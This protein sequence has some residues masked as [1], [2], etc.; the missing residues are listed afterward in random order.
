MFVK[1]KALPVLLLA[2]MLAVLAGYGFNYPSA[3]WDVMLQRAPLLV[4][5]K[6]IELATA[7][8]GQVAVQPVHIENRGNKP[9]IIDHFRISCLCAGLE[10]ENE[11]VYQRIER[12]KIPPRDVLK[13]VM[14]VRINGL[15]GQPLRYDL[16]FRTNDPRHPEVCLPFAV[17]RVTGAILA[18]P[19][20]VIFSDL[21]PN[22]PAAPI[23]V[24][25]YKEKTSK[26]A[27]KNIL[28]DHPEVF[29]IRSLANA[30]VKAPPLRSALGERTSLFAVHLKPSGQ[31]GSM[32]SQIQVQYE[33][34]N[35]PPL[36]IPIIAEVRPWLQCVPDKVHLPRKVNGA[37]V[38]QARFTIK[39]PQP[40]TLLLDQNRLPDGLTI[41]WET[42]AAPSVVHRGVV[43]WQ[44]SEPSSTP[45]SWR[46][47]LTGRME[48][49]IHDASFEVVLHPRGGP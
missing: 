7:E 46:I 23:I 5:P 9:L 43:T 25:I 48:S 19:S 45:A 49:E 6:P 27:I 22:Q 29:A 21:Y 14:R 42:S 44:G 4:P 16:F 1:T 2:S 17:Q 33:D 39:G 31:V 30:D 13:A 24:E 40:F 3:F 11:G 26:K 15:A 32:R 10:M 36:L 20:T 28:V 47:P 12:V 37:W 34:P 38:H 18:V 41:Q 35:E 8:I